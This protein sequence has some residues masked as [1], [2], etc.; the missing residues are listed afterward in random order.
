[1]LGFSLNF[2]LVAALTLV[3]AATTGYGIFQVRATRLSVRARRRWERTLL[4]W[5]IFAPANEP[6]P[7]AMDEL[8]LDLTR[9]DAR[10]AIC[11]GGGALVG[12]IIAGAA[13]FSIRDT[14]LAQSTLEKWLLLALMVLCLLAG[15]I[16]ALLGTGMR[17][18]SRAESRNRRRGFRR[19]WPLALIAAIVLM[20]SA[21]TLA[22]SLGLVAGASPDRSTGLDTLDLHASQWV[23]WVLPVAA[24]LMVSASELTLYLMS[25]RAYPIRSTDAAVARLAA[26]RSLD[27]RIRSFAYFECFFPSL[28]LVQQTEVLGLDFSSLLTLGFAF[29]PLVGMIAGLFVFMAGP[30]W[31]AYRQ[32]APS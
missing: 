15:A 6:P 9:G 12:G 19:W 31:G 28:I 7:E 22:V 24:A 4:S 32:S 27:E 8:A 11:I 3:G 23:L 13:L 30:R 2:M 18:L 21:V 25:R 1:M 20:Y 29:L 14:A 26:E 5:G 10:F 17:V 16:V